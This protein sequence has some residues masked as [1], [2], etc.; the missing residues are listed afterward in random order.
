MRILRLLSW[1]PYLASIR[2]SPLKTWHTYRGLE[3]DSPFHWGGGGCWGIL[4]VVCIDVDNLMVMDVLQET[5]IVYEC[6]EDEMLNQQI[7]YIYIY[8]YDLL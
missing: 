2:K 8:D 4:R 6:T 1:S 7:K 5:N 3:V